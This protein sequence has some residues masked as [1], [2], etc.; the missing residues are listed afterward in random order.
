MYVFVCLCFKELDISSRVSGSEPTDT[1]KCLAGAGPSARF[2]RANVQGSATVE[3]D[4]TDFVCN[5]DDGVV[6]GLASRAKAVKV[7][8]WTLLAHTPIQTL[9]VPT[10]EHL[11][12]RPAASLAILIST[13]DDVPETKL[14]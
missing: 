13:S 2:F 9:T 12:A 5:S 14:A 11:E 1:L 7:A 6:D 4:Q 10:G 3:Y 8:Y